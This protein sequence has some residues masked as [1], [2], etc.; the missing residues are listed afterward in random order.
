MLAAMPTASGVGEPCVGE[1]AAAAWASALDV[2]WSEVTKNGVSVGN[3]SGQHVFFS[4][5]YSYRAA[6][7]LHSAHIAAFREFWPD[8]LPTAAETPSYHTIT[9]ELCSQHLSAW[10]RS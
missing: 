10:Q 6:V 3:Q 7:C 1:E 4:G 9:G 2:L 8:W 5:A